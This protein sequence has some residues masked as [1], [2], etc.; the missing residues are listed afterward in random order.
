MAKTIQ[1][2]IE[3]ASR[4]FKL[5]SAWDAERKVLFDQNKK[6]TFVNGEIKEHKSRPK[7]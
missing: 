4:Y 1:T 5:P 3:A 6:K 2:I 7:H